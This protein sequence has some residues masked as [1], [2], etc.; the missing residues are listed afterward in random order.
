MNLPTLD[1]PKDMRFFS[2]DYF[3]DL[4]DIKNIG[5]HITHE[6]IQKGGREAGLKLLDSFLE[7]RGKNYSKEMS[8][9]LTAITSCSRLS[10]YLT[11]GNLSVRE[12]Y[13]TAKAKRDKLNGIKNLGIG[14]HLYLHF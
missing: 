1:I 2:F 8:S 11:F 14:G 7:T 5:K 10:P 3:F 12:V 4:I 13:K 9:P 6:S